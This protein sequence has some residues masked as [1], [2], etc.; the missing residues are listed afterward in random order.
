ME[1]ETIDRMTVAGLAMFVILSIIYLCWDHISNI[2]L[3]ISVDS[4]T[5]NMSLPSLTMPSLSFDWFYKMD[6]ASRII[7][8]F[9][10]MI[11]VSTII[12][13]TWMYLIRKRASARK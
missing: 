4:P 5:A 9:I 11:L 7:F 10:M 2:L 1:K 6:P 13:G 12:G 3:N 8:V